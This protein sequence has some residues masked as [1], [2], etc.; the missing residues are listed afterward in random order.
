MPH[1]KHRGYLPCHLLFQPGRTKGAARFALDVEPVL[2]LERLQ[3]AVGVL[4][5]HRYI[6]WHQLRDK[7]VTYLSVTDF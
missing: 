1:Y 5:D 7:V 6:Q 4:V 2:E 3:Q